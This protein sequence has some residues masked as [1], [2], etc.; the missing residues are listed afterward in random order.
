MSVLPRCG[1]SH[2]QYN[3]FCSLINCNKNL[4]NYLFNEL[5]YCLTNLR[6]C[7]NSSLTPGRSFAAPKYLNVTKKIVLALD[8]F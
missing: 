8:Q 2:I 3:V 6:S 1:P 7:S 4:V 5:L